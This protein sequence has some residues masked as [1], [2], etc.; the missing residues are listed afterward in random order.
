MT[1]ISSKEHFSIIKQIHIG[2]V[3]PNLINWGHVASLSPA[4]AAK[5]SAHLDGGGGG[6]V[7]VKGEWSWRFM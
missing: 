6:E 5:G 1:L 2:E 3:R 4:I 7:G